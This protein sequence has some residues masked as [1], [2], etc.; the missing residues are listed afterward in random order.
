M[1]RG[2][3]LRAADGARWKVRRRWLERPPPKLRRSFRKNREEA[4]DAFALLPLEGFDAP[5]VLIIVVIVAVL[6]VL[7][8]LPLLGVA[9]ELIALLFLFLSGL[10]ARIVFGRPWIVEA[11]KVGDPETRV[12]YEVKGWRQSS[13]ALSELRA[14]VTSSGQ[15]QTVLG[16]RLATRPAAGDA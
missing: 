12:V 1:S 3:T 7:V 13:Q 9:L 16:R 10:V 4:A 6:I 14:S 2:S 15:P 11:I 8:V 5:M